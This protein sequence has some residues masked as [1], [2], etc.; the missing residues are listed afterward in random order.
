MCVKQDMES[1][2]HIR[3]ETLIVHQA[4]FTQHLYMHKK[5]KPKNKTTNHGISYYL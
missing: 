1:P 3:L 2:G 5:S 4:L